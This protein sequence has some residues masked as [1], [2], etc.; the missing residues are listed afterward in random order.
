MSLTGEWRKRIEHWRGGLQ[1]MWYR[2]LGTVEMAGFV[3]CEQLTGAEAA[4]GEFAPMPV[5]TRWGGKWDYGW[6]RGEVVAPAPAEGR[7]VVLDFGGGGCEALVFVNGEAAGSVSDVRLPIVLADPARAGQAFSV[8]VEAYAGHGPRLC[9]VGPVPHGQPSIPEP[10]ARQQTVA[11]TTFGIWEEDAYQLWLDM[12]CLLELRDGLHADSLRTAE[13]D[14]ALRQATMRVDLELPHDEMPGSLAAGRD[15]LAPVLACTNGSTAPVMFAFGHAHLDVAW[16]WPLAE[17]ERKAAR[18]LANQLALARQYPEYRFLHSQPHLFD[19]VKR[20]YPALYERVRQAVAD[21]SVIA[22]GGM[23][24]ESDTNVPAGESLIRQFVHGKRFFRDEFGVDSVLMWLPDVFGYSGAMPQIMAGCGIKYFS[25]QK[26]FWTYKGGQTFPYNNFTWQGIDG[27]EVLV[28][29]HNNY[30]SQM[31]PA[32][33]I[34]RWRQRVQ[35]DGIRS[36]LMPFGHGDGGGGPTRNHV[37]MARRQKDL[38]GSPLV[39]LDGPVEF[40]EDLEARGAGP[41]RYVGELYFQC[42]RGTYT[43]QAKTKRGNRKS[44][45]ALREAELWSAIAAAR[46]QR[47]FDADEMDDAW[48]KVLL[49][50]F[51]DILPGSSIARVYAEAEALYDE[52]LASADRTAEDARAALTDDSHDM[53]VFNSLSWDR[54]AVVELPAGVGAA[55]D[56]DGRNVCVQDVA[57][58]TIAEVTVPSCGW[59]TLTPIDRPEC[60][61]GDCGPKLIASPDTLE[62]ELIRLTF[63]SRGEIESIFDKAAARELAAGPCNCFKMYKDV[64]ASFD[65]WDLDINYMDQPVELPAE[66]TVEVITAGPLLAVLRITRTLN[67]SAMTQTVTMRRNSRCVDFHTVIDWRE[68]HK[69]LKVAFEVD[70]HAD[71]A[72]HEIQFGHIARPNHHSNRFDADRYEVSNHRWS[73]LAE[74]GRGFGVLNDCKYGLNVL[75][76][77]I[78]LTLLRAAVA[79]D[80]QADLGR[81]EFTYSIYPWTGAFADCDVVREGYELN[82]PVTTAVGSAS[83]HSVFAVDAPGV[84]VDTVKPAAD[85]SGD[86]VVRLYESKATATRAVLSTTLHPATAALCDMLESPV[87]DVPV[88]D[89]HVALD[90]RPFEVKTLRLRIPGGSVG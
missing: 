72:L 13:I 14:Q 5:G 19:M 39:R 79:P 85:R 89:G 80:G 28:H 49:N 2:R 40:F 33:V 54:T 75:G 42:H 90:F 84:I 66:A 9:S 17:T 62:N 31:G 38:E 23:W 18:T 61:G 37:E 87:E 47:P 45:L 11:P 74:R 16:L 71:C 73:A 35:K 25:T 24:V 48:K 8:L 86:V 83:R 27:S 7:R 30:N 60:C 88:N 59:T 52:V 81:Q 6:F 56:A 20:R 55:V 57:G 64:P 26:I 15:V 68:R 10:P 34:D 4:A 43:S 63:N 46:A 41:R 65:A 21:G 82:C 3:T 29:L 76:R 69:V 44:E 50:Q 36:R 77:S 53:T 12:T 78:N 32:A 1:E 51:H 67:Q 70:Y 58:V 22:E